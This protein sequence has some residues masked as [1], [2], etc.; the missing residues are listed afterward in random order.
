MLV[1]TALDLI[2]DFKQDA[3]DAMWQSLGNGANFMLSIPFYHSSGIA[4]MARVRPDTFLFDEGKF[5]VFLLEDPG[6][7][8]LD[9]TLLRE[10]DHLLRRLVDVLPDYMYLKDPSLRLIFLNKANL[11]SMACAGHPEALLGKTDSEIFP[12]D[13]AKKM[14]EEDREVLSGV[15]VIDRLVTVAKPDGTSEYLRLT[16]MPV[17]NADGKLLGIAG[18]TKDV[19]REQT[20]ILALEAAE[21]RF[22]ALVENSLA[23]IFMIQKERI[24]YC[25]PSFGQIFGYTGSEV[26]ALTSF[27]ELVEQNSRTRIESILKRHMES[28]DIDN[29]ETFEG[30]TRDGK[31]V[32]VEFVCTR[33]DLDGTPTLIGTALDLT[34]RYELEEKIRFAHK[35][36]TIGTMAGEIAHDFN[37]LLTVILGSTSLLKLQKNLESSVQDQVHQIH[38][39]AEVATKIT[40]QLLTLSQRR[41]ADIRVRDMN[42]LL[43]K[44]RGMLRHSLRE[45]IELQLNLAEHPLPIQTDQSMFEQVVMN[46]VV[47]ARDAMPNGGV[48]AISTDSIEI[49]EA[50]I[51]RRS[52]EGKPGRYAILEMKDSGC[53]MPP[54]IISHIFEP[55]FTTKDQGRGTGLGMSIVYN[56]IRQHAGWI[57][58]ESEVG[59]GTTFRIFFP[60]QVT[61]KTTAKETGPLIVRRGQGEA[62]LLVEDD[63]R[64]RTLANLCLK[65]LGYSVIEAANA[66]QAFEEWEKHRSE[67]E[68][69][70]C[71]VV[72]PGECSGLDISRRIQKDEPSL[73]I[74]LTSGFNPESNGTPLPP[75][76]AFLPKPYSIEQL[77]QVLKRLFKNRAV[78]STPPPEP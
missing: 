74:L 1:L 22:R 71:D 21:H 52:G 24:T 27:L 32:H 18:I 17:R 38:Q 15:A 47:N 45:N 37:N 4:K 16:K 14:E 46:L 55:Y 67:I 13:E 34:E 43:E 26:L 10:E 2:M 30:L 36:E 5:M 23:G 63:A 54:E 64:V 8:F 49:D 20:S 66:E 19:T 12:K 44:W 41:P 39:A 61:G 65:R 7:S 69:L 40:R 57:D 6:R 51:L 42:E 70:F 53:G 72:L 50:T 3:F 11:E 77:S 48:L 58:L 56:I 31:A 29:T 9:G 76:V 59:R 25:N 75:G 73:P 78:E 62:I 35:M 33:I 28:R 68:L 60:M